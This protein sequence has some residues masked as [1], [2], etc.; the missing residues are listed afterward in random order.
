[1]RT[2]SHSHGHLSVLLRT[3]SGPVLLVGDAA[4]TRRATTEGHDQI[5]RADLA[6]YRNSLESMRRWLR[7]PLSMPP[8]PPVAAALGAGVGVLRFDQS[9]AEQSPVLIHSLDRVAV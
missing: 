3:A 4:T 9:Q 1:M 2:A 7:I 8:G 5:A 6:A